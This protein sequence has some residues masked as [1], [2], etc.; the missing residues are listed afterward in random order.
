MAIKA[1][2]VKK[3]LNYIMKCFFGVPIGI[4]LSLY[5]IV[6]HA[7]NTEQL[8]IIGLGGMLV[9]E[10]PPNIIYFCLCSIVLLSQFTLFGTIINDELQSTS[11]LVIIRSKSRKSWI[12]RQICLVCLLSI[13]I[14]T[15]IT[16]TIIAM[17]F[18]F[19]IPIHNT[20][21][22]IEIMLY[23]MVTSGLCN[24]AFLLLLNLFCIRVGTII[25]VITIWL[26]Y[27]V[28][29]A[30]PAFIQNPFVVK[31]Y[32]STHAILALH[33]IGNASLLYPSFFETT[34]GGF[35]PLYSFIY[36]TVFIILI[37]IVYFIIIVKYDFNRQV[38][39]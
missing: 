14:F 23:L 33:E 9:S 32:P 38:E 17:A 22:I 5:G 16:V 3:N 15:I 28:G 20:I 24:M 26:I 18:I 35:T 7:E 13:I 1:I 30:L 31:A 19:G 6:Y 12:I 37:A 4:I 21:S 25:S 10:F 34:I 27:L 29:Q 11:L 2:K 36:C 39:N 8:L